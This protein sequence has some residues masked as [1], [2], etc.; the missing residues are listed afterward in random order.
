MHPLSDLL[1]IMNVLIAGGFKLLYSFSFYMDASNLPYVPDLMFYV[2]FLC[3]W[4]LLNAGVY[5][6]VS[7]L[8]F[9]FDVSVVLYLFNFFAPV[10]T[11]LL[12]VDHV[13]L[14]FY[15]D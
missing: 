1:F 8:F 11:W 7:V 10:Y 5:K 12:I 13:C 6:D 3:V 15:S 2:V 4:F 9:L 14:H